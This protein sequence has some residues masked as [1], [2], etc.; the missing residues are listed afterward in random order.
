MSSNGWVNSIPRRSTKKRVLT[1]EWHE[2]AKSDNDSWNSSRPS[3]KAT[4]EQGSKS[5]QND[6]IPSRMKSKRAYDSTEPY[7]SLSQNDS[8]LLKMKSNRE[9]SSSTSNNNKSPN[10]PTQND[11]TSPK[12]KSQWDNDSFV[13]NSR[14]SSSS[15]ASGNDP[16]SSINTRP[17]LYSG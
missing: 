15:R 3:R 2:L 1:D 14:C 8:T 10:N 17:P 9:Y 7:S 13:N 5:N 16:Q 6:S 12:S 11:S 4:M